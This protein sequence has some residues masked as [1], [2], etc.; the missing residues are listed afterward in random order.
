MALFGLAAAG[1]VGGRRLAK[2]RAKKA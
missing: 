1:A 2:K